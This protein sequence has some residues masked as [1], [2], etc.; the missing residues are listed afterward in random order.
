MRV[1]NDACLETDG[2]SRKVSKEKILALPVIGAA[3]H[4]LM[5]TFNSQNM[6]SYY[7]SIVTKSSCNRCRVVSM[8]VMSSTKPEVLN[9]VS[10]RRQRRAE[11]LPKVT[12]TV[13][14]E[15]WPYGFQDMRA[16]RQTELTCSF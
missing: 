1:T 2:Q 5:F 16:D 12:C 13:T 8:F 6:T 7:C 15:I 14:G 4:W 11:T 10:Q 9:N 3:R